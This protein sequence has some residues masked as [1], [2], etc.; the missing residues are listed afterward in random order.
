MS[1]GIPDS[2]LLSTDRP[3]GLIDRLLS[4]L[5]DIP[6]EA[7]ALK[8][9][10]FRSRILSYRK[11]L[12]TS[13]GT[14]DF[15]LYSTDCLRTC[16]E[17]FNLTRK[18]MHER[19]SAFGEVIQVLRESIGL[20]A[21]ESGSFNS[22]LT[23]TS[24]RFDRLTEIADIHKL[25]KQISL[26]CHELKRI[27]TEKQLK[28]EASYSQLSRRVELLQGSLEQTREEA[29]L[30]G[31]TRIANRSSFDKALSR[32]I[33]AHNSAKKPFILAILD[34]DDFKAINDRHGHQIGDRVLHCAAQW[35]R[36]CVRAN[37]FLAR[38]GGEE[39]AILL[40][41]ATTEQALAKFSSL[42]ENIAA[43][44]YKYTVA[45]EIANVSFTVSCGIAEFV[46]EESGENLVRRADAAMYE[47]KHRGK[48]R[49]VVSNPPQKSKGLWSALQP[50]IPFKI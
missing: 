39:F 40:S 16:E 17:Y 2:G 31:L 14:A 41:D 43:S 26:E 22:Q 44:S 12:A 27:V 3:Q 19:E 15:G 25:K 30:D 49:V 38:F 33:A 20:L 50:L 48:N 6:V 28:D 13:F 5:S 23:R 29:S 46:P 21:G 35:F 36:K 45:G 9:G 7:D 11:R 4:I 47:A 18:Y 42:L 37:D 1:E 34:L 10:E 24:E 8:T 32:W